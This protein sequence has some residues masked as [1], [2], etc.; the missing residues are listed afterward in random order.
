MNF[1]YYTDIFSN[2]FGKQQFWKESPLLVLESMG[3]ILIACAILFMIFYLGY[4]PLETTGTTALLAVT[5]WR[6]LP[7]WN[8][9]VSSFAGIRVSKPYVEIIFEF[10]KKYQNHQSEVKVI[11]GNNF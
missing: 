9:V 6:T 2:Y 3:F 10:F 8:R 4:S 5:A 1:K 7:A 11:Y